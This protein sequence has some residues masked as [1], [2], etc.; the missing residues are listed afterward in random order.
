MNCNNAK[1]SA[2]LPGLPFFFTD[3]S[4]VISTWQHW[5]SVLNHKLYWTGTLFFNFGNHLVN[6][7]FKED[8]LF[9]R[10]ITQTRLVLKTTHILPTET[11]CQRT[12]PKLDV[13][14]WNT[15]QK[16]Q[17]IFQIFEFVVNIL[18]HRFFHAQLRLETVQSFFDSVSRNVFSHV[19]W[20]FLIPMLVTVQDTFN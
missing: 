9:R 16:K 17:T 15:F 6:F 11:L 13:L 12:H 20:V 14:R 8:F 10:F 18:C 3:Y 1:K 2:M 19:V 5:K 7:T 4:T